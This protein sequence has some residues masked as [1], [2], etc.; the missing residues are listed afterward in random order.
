[1]CDEEV[2]PKVHTRI[3]T[4][5]FS[6]GAGE[7]CSLRAV[8]GDRDARSTATAT[9]GRIEGEMDAHGARDWRSAQM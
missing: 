2:V 7:E 1:M 3:S 5:R 9:R 6:S 4:S 8:D